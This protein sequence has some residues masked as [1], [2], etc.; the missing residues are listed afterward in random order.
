MS[1]EYTTYGVTVSPRTS[2]R[3]PEFAGSLLRGT[4]GKAMRDLAC[5]TR[6]PACDGCRV[7]DTCVYR[8]VMEPVPPAT[9]PLQRFSAI[10]PPFVL[11]L[12]H[13]GAGMLAG[14]QPL[15]FGITLVGRARRHL[16][17]VVLALQRSAGEGWTRDRVMFDLLRVTSHADGKEIQVI[18]PGEGKLKTHPSSDVLHAHATEISRERKVSIEILT[19]ARLQQ[20]GRPAKPE[21]LSA[22]TWLMALVRRVSLLGDFHGS[23]PLMFD[24]GGLSAAAGRCLISQRQLRWQD[25]ERWSA[26]QQRAMPMGGLVGSFTLE[27]ELGAFMPVM[28]FA[29]R[30]HVGKHASFGLGAYRVLAT[31]NAA[32]REEP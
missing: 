23:R 12:H 30:L 5:V 4:F 16:P 11:H 29:Q 10:P 32:I 28:R 7:A 14:G 2:V 18:D 31:S 22:R 9:H 24:F 1:L 20:E 8:A 21:D 17:L 19:P 25:W 6:A 27:G 3:L 26:K 15:R 13:W